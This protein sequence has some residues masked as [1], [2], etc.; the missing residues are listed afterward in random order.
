MSFAGEFQKLL[1]R[2]TL[3]NQLNPDGPAFRPSTAVV[4][5]KNKQVKKPSINLVPK[6]LMNNVK[7]S[8]EASVNSTPLAHLGS[9]QAEEMKQ[10]Q[11]K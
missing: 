9:E 2:G 7:V 5:S 4:E 10:R 6:E 8:E 11:S 1:R 3:F